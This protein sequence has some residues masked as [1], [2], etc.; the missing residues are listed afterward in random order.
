MLNR[1]INFFTSLRLTVACLVAAIVLV[2]VGT[3]AQV[4]LGLYVTQEKY[5]RSLFVFWTPQGTDWRIPVWPGGYLLGWLLLI[6]LIAAHIQRFKLTWKKSGIFLIHFGLIFLLVGQFLTELFQVESFMRIPE[7]ESRNYSEDGRR[8]ELAI[9]DV[10]APDQDRV[11]AIPESLLKP[12][13]EI[14]H[15]D[16]PFGIRVKELFAN[17]WP[18]GPMTEAKAKRIKAGQGIGQRLAFDEE[19]ITAK[20]NDENKPTAH[21]EIVGASGSLGDWLVSLWLT[22]YPWVQHLSE[23]PQIG[24]VVFQPQQFTYEG[25]TY[26]IALRPVRYYKPHTLHLLDFTHARYRGTDIPKDFSSR[27]RLTHAAT[28][29]DREILIYMNNPLRYGGETY[30]QGG[31]EP[32]DTVTILQVVRNPAWLTPYF[33]CVLVAGGM[34]V[35]FLMHLIGFARRRSSGGDAGAAKAQP[36]KSKARSPRSPNRAVEAA[37][38]ITASMTRAAE[39]RNG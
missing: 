7:G 14:R 35:Q 16:L 12:G 3:L 32:G 33:A 8:N 30:Y 31:F 37:P 17:S 22:K 1:I 27:V 6:N 34:M 25:R 10:T 38:A 29:E 2:F 23:S 18:A 19:A 15:P 5:F 26:Q 21:L 28:G 4:N 11:V 39:R 24:S 13:G 36:S 20:M 9:I